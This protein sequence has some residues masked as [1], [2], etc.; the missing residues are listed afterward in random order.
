[1]S[2]DALQAD[3]PLARAGVVNPHPNPEHS[4]LNTEYSTRNTEQG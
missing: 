4:T 1:M 3:A 2:L